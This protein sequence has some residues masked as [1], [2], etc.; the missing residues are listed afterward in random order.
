[1]DRKNSEKK[2]FTIQVHYGN[3][4]SATATMEEFETMF[5]T[6]TARL[7]FETPNYKIRTGSFATEREALEVLTRVK[8]VF[9]A[10]FVLKP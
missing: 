6:L 1:M 5:P 10:A 7:I 8:R 2:L 3:Y 9:K 4:E